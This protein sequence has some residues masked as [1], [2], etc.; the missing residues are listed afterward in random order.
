MM[1]PWRSNLSE[2]ARR[3]NVYCKLSG[4][5]TEAD[6]KSWS[7]GELRPYVEVALTAFGPRR[8]MIG[9]DWPVCLLRR[10][11]ANGSTPWVG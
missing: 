5:V 6:W 7:E 1:E 2:L 11:I 10:T 4:L 9:S 3:E 8:M